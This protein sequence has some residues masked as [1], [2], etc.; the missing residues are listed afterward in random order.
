MRFPAIRGAGH[1]STVRRANPAPT[2]SF[3]M[4]P[5]GKREVAVQQSISRARRD[6]ER[7]AEAGFTL[8][9]MLC[10]VAILAILAAIAVPALPRNTSRARLESYAVATAA[11]LKADRN[12]ALRRNSEVATQVDAK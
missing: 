1:T 3:R 9:E 7:S 6:N 10:V 8:V 12:A 5:M 2:T 4:V 11:L